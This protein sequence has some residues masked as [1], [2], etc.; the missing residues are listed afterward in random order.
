MLANPEFR[1]ADAERN[2]RRIVK[3]AAKLLAEDPHAGMAAIAEAAGVTRV[4]VNR[5]FKTRENLVAAVFERM[6]VR[7]AEVMRDCRLEE[8]PA[9]EALERLVQ[10]WLGDPSL[11]LPVHVLDKG[12]SVL[13]PEV[14]QH[15]FERELGPQVL[16]L[17]ARGRASGEFA[18]LP[19][20]WMARLFGA[21]VRAA[22]EAIEAGS[23]SRGAAPDLVT[24]SLLRGLIP[25][26]P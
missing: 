4:T 24:R 6:L 1:R 9:S 5:H 2:G 12:A 20:E 13:P 7:A 17:M 14:R 19:A 3:A 10:G 16:A 8:G 22:M 23:L 15:H 18:D 26:T 25:P 21:A 11:L